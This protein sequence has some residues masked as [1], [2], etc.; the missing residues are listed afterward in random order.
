M[1]I[2]FRHADRRF[3]FTWETPGQPPARYHGVGEGPVQY[4]ADTPDGAWAE[5]LRH[6]EITDA[7]ELD[8]IERRIWAVEVPDDDLA[9]VMDVALPH[10]TVVGGVDTYGACRDAARQARAAGRGGIRAPSAA[11][12]DGGGWASGV[13]GLGPAT[14]RPAEVVALFG[15]G[16][17]WRG[18]MCHDT[19]SPHPS[20]LP[21]VRSAH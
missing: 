18:W 16:A 5:F 6:E 11:L 15:T 4:F 21:L 17:H 13:A 8:G 7:D 14:P 2:L 20:L 9:S 12:I 10:A 19:G 1:A 3:G